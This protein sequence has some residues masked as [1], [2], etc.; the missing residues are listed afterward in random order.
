[1][2]VLRCGAGQQVIAGYRVCN[3]AISEL[4]HTDTNG[5]LKGVVTR[6]TVKGVVIYKASLSIV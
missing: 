4:E 2:S 1:M 5:R 3:Y 6:Q